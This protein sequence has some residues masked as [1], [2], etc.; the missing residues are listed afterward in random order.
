MSYRER[1]VDGFQ[2]QLRAWC[3]GR[4]GAPRALVLAWLA[5]VLV[6]LWQD[7]AIGGLL[8]FPNLFSGINLGIHELGHMVFRP[9]GR[10]MEI[11]GGSLLQC[12]APIAGMVMQRRE[13]DWFGICFCG[14][15]LATNL[16]SV[17][18]YMADARAQSLP[19]V[20]PFSS[21]PLHD[22]ALLFGDFGLLDSCEQIGLGFKLLA[23]VAMLLSLAGGAV[24]VGFMLDEE[25]PI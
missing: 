9:L 8:D 18:V 21:H 1:A 7:P 5:W 11:A 14:G 12:M 17:G 4:H 25:E 22:Y 13:G 19:L 20:S 23:S 24:L 6:Y 2:T 3:R 15:W 10:T 16:F